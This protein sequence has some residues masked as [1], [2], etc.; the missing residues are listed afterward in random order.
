MK[1]CDDGLGKR[2]ERTAR[3]LSSARRRRFM[4][5]I[6]LRF[7]SYGCWDKNGP[8]PLPRHWVLETYVVPYSG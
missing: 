4:T 7:E 3:E 6:P 1:R 2:G 8:M 5:L